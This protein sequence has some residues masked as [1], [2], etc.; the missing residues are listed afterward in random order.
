MFSAALTIVLICGAL[1]ASGQQDSPASPSGD[2]QLGTSQFSTITVGDKVPDFTLYDLHGS[3]VK[4]S[5]LQ[6]DVERNKTGVVALSFWCSLCVSCRKVEHSLNQ[7]AKDY[8]GR[9][10]IVALG[11]DVRET[12]ET[13]AAFAKEVGLTLPIFLDPSG[14]TMDLFANDLTTTT[15]LIDSDGILRY[16]G[17][18]SQ[19]ERAYASDALNAV[20]A[21]REVSVKTTRPSG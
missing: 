2:K 3:P 9:A 4:L 16:T 12:A 20:L 11:A 15:V 14:V 6:K 21:G 10:A 7:L 13:A 8:E 5:Q 1:V 18:F 19:G 17:R